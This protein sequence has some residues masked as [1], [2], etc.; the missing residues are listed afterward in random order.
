MR[1]SC[2]GAPVHY[3]LTVRAHPACRELTWAWSSF[4]HSGAPVHY[5]Q[6]VRAHPAC[7]ELTWAWSSFIRS[8][9]RS[10]Y[11][12][13]ESLTN[14]LGSVSRGIKL[15]QLMHDEQRVTVRGRPVRRG[16]PWTAER[17][18]AA[19]EVAAV[20]RCSM[21][22]HSQCPPGDGCDGPACAALRA[23]WD[24]PAAAAC[25]SPGCWHYMAAYLPPACCKAAP[26]RRTCQKLPKTSFKTF[27]NPH[28]WVKN[29]AS[30]S[31]AHG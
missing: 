22:T 3:G 5:E 8:F 2:T 6:T 20:Y 25:P 16:A 26:C 17:S 15:V 31:R 21:S 10:R 9:L 14:S 18:R 13:A 27:L 11:R 29:T 30:D 23:G 24:W 1:R 28:S 12:R 4:L 7:R 19:S